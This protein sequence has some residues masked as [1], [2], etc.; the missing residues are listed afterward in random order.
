MEH[1]PPGDPAIR[2]IRRFGFTPFGGASLHCI[3]G[4]FAANPTSA[5]P[6]LD[7]LQEFDGSRDGGIALADDEVHAQP[8]AERH[9]DVVHRGLPELR[10]RTRA[11]SRHRP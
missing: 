1:T 8:F 2:K 5:A 9:E 6:V 3:F 4:G 7:A 11:L 10:H